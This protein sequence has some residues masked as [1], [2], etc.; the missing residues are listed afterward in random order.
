LAPFRWN[1]FDSKLFNEFFE[2]SFSLRWEDFGV[3]SEL[4]SHLV[5]FEHWTFLMHVIFWILMWRSFRV[6][7]R[8]WNCYRFELY[9]TT[10]FLFQT[11]S[12]VTYFCVVLLPNWI[13]VP[14]KFSFSKLF[15]FFD[16]RRLHQ[17][18]PINFPFFI[19]F[20]WTPWKIEG[21]LHLLIT[22]NCHNWC[23]KLDCKRTFTNQQIY[24]NLHPF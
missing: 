10:S 17:H 20:C 13:F 21:Q 24:L 9:A 16:H 18:L 2:G 4:G 3:N 22:V 14:F 15:I 11:G 5:V 23:A 7:L 19:H 8:D 6:D 1:V 12:P